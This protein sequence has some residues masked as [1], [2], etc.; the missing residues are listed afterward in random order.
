MFGNTEAGSKKNH[1]RS[2][3]NPVEHQPHCKHLG[4]LWEATPDPK[5]QFMFTDI[6]E[7]INSTQSAFVFFEIE[8]LQT[9]MLISGT[10]SGERVFMRIHISD[11]S[12]VTG[13][14]HAGGVRGRQFC[15]RIYSSVWECAC[16]CLGVCVRACSCVRV[17]VCVC[18]CVCLITFSWTGWKGSALHFPPRC[19]ICAFKRRLLA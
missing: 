4:C 3:V 13:C 11:G 19:R 10:A 12:A 18:V 9:E 14:D 5:L 2:G 1:P 7:Y 15:S 16:V 8:T 6:M 17:Y